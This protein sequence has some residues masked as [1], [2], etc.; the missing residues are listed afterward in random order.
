M[1]LTRFSYFNPIDPSQ[2]LLH[3]RAQKPSHTSPWDCQCRPMNTY[4][5]GRTR[6]MALLAAS[7]TCKQARSNHSVL[8]GRKPPRTKAAHAPTTEQL[9][10]CH[11]TCSTIHMDSRSL[12]MLTSSRR[13]MQWRHGLSQAVGMALRT[14]D[15]RDSD[16]FLIRKMLLHSNI[17]S[18][19]TISFSLRI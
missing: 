9:Q 10:L 15:R 2:C 18:C 16:S 4:L 14:V 12:L 17:S 1:W 7:Q 5:L 19:P 3:S 8:T 13:S 6:V 11:P